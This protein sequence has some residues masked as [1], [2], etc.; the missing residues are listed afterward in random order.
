LCLVYEILYKLLPLPLL[1]A[2]LI[3]KHFAGCPR[4]REGF[5]QTDRAVRELADTPE[6]VTQEQSLW[7]SIRA[8]ILE[9]QAPAKK[10]TLRPDPAGRRKWRWAAAGFSLTLM[11]S[12]NLLIRQAEHMTA[13]ASDIT[14]AEASPDV[15][16]NFAEIRGRKARHYI[17]QTPSK[18]YIWFV[19]DKDSGGE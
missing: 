6:W 3:E 19:Q 18:S 1:R 2:L 12:F 9:L 14:P 5:N 13:A 17:Y 10:K 11:L 4:C 15:T 16:V 7:P 8:R